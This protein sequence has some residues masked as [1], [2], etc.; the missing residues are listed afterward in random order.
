MISV[1]TPEHIAFRNKILFGLVVVMSAVAIWAYFNWPAISNI[2]WSRDDFEIWFGR[3][4]WRACIFLPTQQGRPVAVIFAAL[5]RLFSQISWPFAGFVGRLIQGTMHCASAVIIGW[6]LQRNRKLPLMYFVTLPFL[7][8]PL[9]GEATYW[10]ASYSD[11]FSA[12]VSLLGIV[13]VVHWPVPAPRKFL[14]LGF[15]L[16]VLSTLINQGGCLAGF[17][18]YSMLVALTIISR[19]S[20]KRILSISRV[21]IIIFAYCLGALISYLVATSLK[22]ERALSTAIMSLSQAIDFQVSASR[23][24]VLGN[25]YFPIWLVFIQCSLILMPILSIALTLFRRTN[26]WNDRILR[27]MV[28]ILIFGV[29]IVLPYVSQFIVGIKNS[30]ISPRILYLSPLVMVFSLALTME[31]GTRS[32]KWS[33]GALLVFLLAMYYPI[34]IRNASE[35]V[36]TFRN[37]LNKLSSI[38][39]LAENMGANIVFIAN[40]PPRFPRVINP[41]NIQYDFGDSKKSAFNRGW[42]SDPFIRA[43]SKKIVPTRDV[44]VAKKC[45]NFCEDAAQNAVHIEEVYDKP[46]MCFCP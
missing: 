15:L 43:F 9:N 44:I 19:D 35:H 28:V 41:Y 2:W 3:T 4:S 40:Y 14:Y 25:N 5:M 23:V 1:L 21:A 32:I 12:F 24:F 38:D 27:A 20:D 36:T 18:C 45:L 31:V 26:S 22:D 33:S 17:I 46:I 6:L 7:V 11:P 13:F 39:F 37:D 16:I 10:L 34:S 8:W 30:W 29:V 42:S